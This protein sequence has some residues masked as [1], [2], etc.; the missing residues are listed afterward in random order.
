MTF[1]GHFPTTRLRR[2]RQKQWIR[3]L[4][5]ESSLTVHDLILPIFLRTPEM[6]PEIPSLPDVKRFTLEELPSLVETISHVGIPAVALFPVVSSSLKTDRGC[7]ALNPDNLICQAIQ[8]FKKYNP[9][10][11]VITDVA[12][13]PYT[14]HGHDGLLNNQQIDNDA[15]LDVLCQQ[16]LIQAQSG[17]DAIAP[18][19]MMDGRVGAIRTFLDQ[20]GFCQTLILS[21]AAK[22]ASSFYGPFRQAI[23]AAP[24]QGIIDKKTYQMNPANSREALREVSQDLQEGADMIIVKP[25]MP[26]L[27]VIHHVSHTFQIPTLAFQVSGEYAA[28]IAAGQKGWINTDQAMTES[29]LAFKRAGACAILTYWALKMAKHLLCK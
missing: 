4:V 3:D 19:D 23:D 20:K 10:L 5:A 16:A 8:G 13:D 26:Y 6:S 25:G 17:A 22:Y 9:A 21:Y 24:L 27:D 7:E 18:S 2:L 1:P 29:L 28:L 15:T 12:L 11:G 14:T